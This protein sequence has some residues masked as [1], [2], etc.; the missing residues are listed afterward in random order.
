MTML[1]DGGENWKNQEKYHTFSTTI[2]LI[3][4]KNWT[5]GTGCSLSWYGPVTFFFSK[6]HF[7]L[8][9]SNHIAAVD[10]PEIIIIVFHILKPFPNVYSAV[11]PSHP[12]PNRSSDC[13]RRTMGEWILRSSTTNNCYIIKWMINAVTTFNLCCCV[14]AA[15]GE[16]ISGINSSLPAPVVPRRHHCA[17][18]A[19]PR[20]F[21]SA[22][23]EGA[24]APL[25]LPV[26]WPARDVLC[27]ECQLVETGRK[28]GTQ[29]FALKQL[30]LQLNSFS[31][32]CQSTF[33]SA[34]EQ[35]GFELLEIRG[36]DPRLAS[37]DTLSGEEIPLHL[38]FRL[39]GYII[40]VGGSHT[41][42]TSGCIKSTNVHMSLILYSVPGGV[43]VWA[44][45]ELPVAWTFEAQ[46]RHGQNLCSLQIAWLWASCWSVWQVIHVW[47][48]IA[49]RFG[50]CSADLNIMKK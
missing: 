50:F 21:A 49:F 17:N 4:S 15:N 30:K 38:L 35:K 45:W 3:F 43:P 6:V 10:L 19:F 8:F 47:I 48:L 1:F 14:P 16:E 28:C 2:I 12:E 33:L 26:H 11:W 46:S 25:Q 9:L 23:Q 44:D 42:Q 13:Q 18:A 27:S 34:A 20:C 31:N 7:S 39:H 36:Q 5:F 40:Q 32:F 41:Y 24:R 37:L 22:W 29:Y